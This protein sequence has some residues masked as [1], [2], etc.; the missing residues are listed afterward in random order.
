MYREGHLS[1]WLPPHNLSIF[2][3]YNNN[4]YFSGQQVGKVLFSFCYLESGGVYKS[5]GLSS[6]LCF[7]KFYFLIQKSWQIS[8]KHTLVFYQF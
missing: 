2:I 3:L 7:C 5:V 1:F 4:Y 8:N 6:F